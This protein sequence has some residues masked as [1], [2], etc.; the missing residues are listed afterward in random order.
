MSKPV[1]NIRK[2]LDGT[3]SC[4]VIYP[5]SAIKAIKNQGGSLHDSWYDLQGRRLSG[6]PWQKGLYIHNG[7]KESI[8]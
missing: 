2:S 6:K 5:P 8:R 4:D 1:T 7:R 3:I